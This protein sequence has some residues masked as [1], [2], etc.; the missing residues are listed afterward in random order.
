MWE[1]EEFKE[2]EGFK[3]R[4]VVVHPPDRRGAAFRIPLLE[5]IYFIHGVFRPK[6][7]ASCGSLEPV[8]GP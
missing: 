7:V 3:I 4:S 1:L 8:A 2:F 6:R 5:T